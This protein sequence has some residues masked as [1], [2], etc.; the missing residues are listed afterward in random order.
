[1]CNISVLHTS[2]RIQYDSKEYRA[3]TKMVTS[4]TRFMYKEKLKTLKR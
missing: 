4:L 3:T 1:M 2:A